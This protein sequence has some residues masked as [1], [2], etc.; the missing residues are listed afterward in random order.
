[1]K[2]CTCAHAPTAGG[3]PQEPWLPERSPGI[4]NL[5]GSPT[6]PK[7]GPQVPS[8]EEP[9]QPADQAPRVNINLKCNEVCPTDAVLKT[10]NGKQN[11][12]SSHHGGPAAQPKPNYKA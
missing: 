2:P 12:G 9:E 11:C 4:V 8:S 6:F 1:M 5:R 3:D 10:A 7:T